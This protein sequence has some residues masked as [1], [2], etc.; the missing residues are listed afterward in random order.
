[1]RRALFT[2]TNKTCNLFVCQNWYWFKARHFNNNNNLC[3]TYDSYL[4]NLA[5]YRCRWMV[6]IQ[7]FVLVE[8]F[9]DFRR[10]LFIVAQFLLCFWTCSLISHSNRLNLLIFALPT[11]KKSL[12]TRKLHCIRLEISQIASSAIY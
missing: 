9:D 3:K 6:F 10:F 1:M 11:L 12:E 8:C 4:P 5:S 7:V 2:H